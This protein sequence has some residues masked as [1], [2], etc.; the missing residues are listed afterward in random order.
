M[1]V[2]VFAVAFLLVGL[3]ALAAQPHHHAAAAGSAAVLLSG[4]G[5][6]HH[7]IA[8]RNAR[9]QSFFDQG[10][11]LVF[12]FNHGEAV[13]SFERA[14]ALD[15]QA[16]MPLWGIA[17]ALGPNINLDVDPEREQRAY[18]AVQ[19]ASVLAV[20]APA[21]ERAY[22]EALAT[23]YSN[24]PNADLRKLAVDYKNA[25]GAL[26]KHYP[27]DLD[28]ATLYAE[29]AMDLRPWHLWN[30]DGTP[31]EGTEEIVDVLESVLKRDPNHIGANHYYIHAIEASPHPERALP[32]A[33]RLERLVTSAGHLVHMP[34][35][36]YMRTGDYAG[37]VAR[38]AAAAA[39]D[40]AYLAQSGAQGVY[41]V[42]YYSHNLQFLAMAASMMGRFAEAKRAADQLA[43]NVA[44]AVAAMPMAEGYLPLPTFVLL[45]FNRTAEVLR[46]P[47]PNPEGPLVHVFW[48]FARGVAAAQRGDVTTADSEREAFEVA[49]RAVPSDA[50]MGLNPA[51]RVLTIAA[52]VLDAR[53]ITARGNRPQA[54]EH[55]RQAVGAQDALAYDE[56][57]FWYY[58]V[59]E[60]LGAALLLNGDAAAAEQVFRDDLERN[61]RNP[62]SLFGLWQS[63]QAQH[64][65]ADAGW[66]HR[67]F[68]TAWQ[69]AEVRLRLEDL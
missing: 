41:P 3:S 40:R 26:S 25:M 65:D 52:Q 66:V 31:A 32:S 19:K 44:P 18:A 62:R 28:A 12:A 14:A 1:K 42:M 33:Q 11:K 38:N 63:L 4:L 46:L 49:S 57:P 23:R 5:T 35:H 9:T 47:E 27:D 30:A 13:R 21:P 34:S 60:S 39:A 67:E 56:P 61:P 20:Q 69:H 24:D 10:I 36:I 68:V 29:A 37:A 45:R 55:W 16:V 15:P 54:I 51:A 53:I 48:H 6:H 7:P 59:R 50:V 64:K 17:L 43:V 8:T 22:V 2:F 58:P